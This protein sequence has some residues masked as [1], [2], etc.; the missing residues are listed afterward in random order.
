[1]PDVVV[2]GSARRGFASGLLGRFEIALGVVVGSAAAGR[3]AVAIGL[4]VE[5]V[6]RTAGAVVRVP[7]LSALLA[8]RLEELAR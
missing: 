1:M 5:L 2:A 3:V 6:A 8:V 7:R 4:F